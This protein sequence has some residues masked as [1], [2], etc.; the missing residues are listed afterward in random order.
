VL[1]QVI[2]KMQENFSR[3]K[4]ERFLQLYKAF[5]IWPTWVSLF[6]LLPLPLILLLSLVYFLYPF[7]SGGGE[8]LEAIQDSSG[9]QDLQLDME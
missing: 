1:L 4:V 9:G 2:V 5:L 6:P 3:L 7:L 8:V